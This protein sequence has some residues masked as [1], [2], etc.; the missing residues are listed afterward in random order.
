MSLVLLACS[1]LHLRC[2]IL[3]SL[4][5]TRLHGVCLSAALC[6]ASR[7]LTARLLYTGTYALFTP[8][9]AHA[10]RVD[11]LATPGL[12]TPLRNASLLGAVREHGKLVGGHNPNAMTR[13][14]TVEPLGA[15]ALDGCGDA[16]QGTVD[17]ANGLRHMSWD[18][19]TL[20]KPHLRERKPH[21]HT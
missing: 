7:R 11:V 20:G 2:S 16:D 9:P 3:I 18:S 10:G 6:S 1:C 15:A 5:L 19:L 12:S 13:W 4:L 21:V 14:W 8:V 17:A